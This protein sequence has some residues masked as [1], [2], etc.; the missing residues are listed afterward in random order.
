MDKLI[1]P[2][3][4]P[5]PEVD[6][7]AIEEAGRSLKADGEAV[8]QSGHDI[9]DTWQGLSGAYV[10]PESETLLAAVSPVATAGDDFAE[11]TATVGNAL[12]DFAEE[13]RPIIQELKGYRIQ[14]RELVADVDGD[15]D[16]RANEDFVDRNNRLNFWV[17]S[18]QNRYME[19][20][21]TCANAITGLFGG[22][23]FVGAD[24]GGNTALKDGQ[25]EYGYDGLSAY[26]YYG[27]TPWGTYQEQDLPWFMDAWDGVKDW[28]LG[29]AEDVG[30]ALGV[31]GESGWFIAGHTRENLAAYWPETLR[32]AFSLTGL[33]SQSRGLES[34]LSGHWW[35]NFSTAW[36]GVAHAYVPWREWDDRPGYVVTQATINIGLTFAGGF[37]AARSVWHGMRGAS[38]GHH[39]S[40]LDADG[41]ETPSMASRPSHATEDP[42]GLPTTRDLQIA[43]AELKLDNEQLAGL[44][45]TLDDAANL[46]DRQPV[47]MGGRQPTDIHA[48]ASPDASSPRTTGGDRDSAPVTDGQPGMGTDTSGRL[49]QQ[50][51]DGVT[52]HRGTEGDSRP[53]QL[54][55]NGGPLPSGG[56][57]TPP[58]DRP[59]AGNGD[60]DS[61]G[62]P[63]VGDR[64][65]NYDGDRLDAQG[66]QTRDV[67]SEGDVDAGALGRSP[68]EHHRD[69][70]GQQERDADQ[71]VTFSE[72]EVRELALEIRDGAA[73]PANS[74][75]VEALREALDAPELRGANR[76]KPKSNAAI[77]RFEIEGMEPQTTA[78][79]SGR[80]IKN[81]GLVQT[82][83]DRIFSANPRSQFDSEAKLLEDLATRLPDNPRGSIELYTERP[84]C[85]S[86]R[87]VITQFRAQFPQVDIKVTWGQNNVVALDTRRGYV[88]PYTS[89]YD[90]EDNPQDK[91]W[92]INQLPRTTQQHDM[93]TWLKYNQD[94]DTTQ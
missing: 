50:G 8:A 73:P 48:S 75:G 58:A 28:A 12:M 88:D 22:T 21:R 55:G 15:P 45:R 26:A 74:L 90:A 40:G 77:M 71:D 19:A 89:R 79:A 57:G 56:D 87:R 5:V 60:G 14:A 43:L 80:A 24:P 44:D 84:P 91:L 33:Y 41:S 18:A 49:P 7:D 85:S 61:V 4:I 29:T 70:A 69:G 64:V 13:I 47:V 6:P 34:P 46:R 83:D 38:H 72:D 27:E 16:W 68:E 92:V 76:I 53:D 35:E 39:D 86:C 65:P 42:A 32:G 31:Y 36:E 20:E 9:N 25:E 17:L 30:G 94:M 59:G 62:Q 37:G 93:K 52:Q 10:A 81:D 2:D 78:A 66:V 1:D 67:S 63:P 3:A 82:P 51:T 11:A 23:T 54:D